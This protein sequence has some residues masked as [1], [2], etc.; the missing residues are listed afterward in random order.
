MIGILT[1]KPSAA[2]NFA[3]ALGAH[4]ATTVGSDDKEFVKSLGADEVIDYK[5]E[6]FEEMLKDF[7]A[8]YDTV[9]GETT[10]NS[11]KVLSNFKSCKRS[12]RRA[13]TAKL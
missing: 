3:K 4:V 5:N 8:V 2:R 12:K 1:E 11:F 7:D 10:T 9:G 13:H 6:K